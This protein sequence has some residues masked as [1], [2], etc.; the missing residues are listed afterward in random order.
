[1][2]LGLIRTGCLLFVVAGLAV[3]AAAQGRDVARLTGPYKEEVKEEAPVSGRSLLGLFVGGP[4]WSAT[5]DISVQSKAAAAEE[6]VCLTI[7]SRDGRYY[8]RNEYNLPSRSSAEPVQLPVETRHPEIFAKAPDDGIAILVENGACDVR[9]PVYRI[10][11]IAPGRISRTV[12]ALV[13]TGRAEATLIVGDPG[14]ETRHACSPISEGKRTTFDTTCALTL[15]P[16]ILG[17]AL[18]LQLELCSFGE[19]RR[20]RLGVMI[21]E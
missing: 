20:S 18:P 7:V 15:P 13:N 2:G 9:Q 6:R 12:T 16:E 10:A 19:C 4:S 21:D 8:A 17:K 11:R 14:A 3:T 1:M 5:P